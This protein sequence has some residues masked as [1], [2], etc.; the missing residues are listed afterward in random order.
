MLSKYI[1]NWFIL[2]FIL[3]IIMEKFKIYGHQF[4]NVYYTS[5]LTAIGFFVLYGYYLYQGVVFESSFL[6]FQLFTHISPIVILVRYYN[7][8][9]KN[10]LKTLLIVI[11]L[12]ILY[13]KYTNKNIDDIYF[14]KEKIIKTWN[15]LENSCIKNDNS[16]LCGIYKYLNVMISIKIIY[17]MLMINL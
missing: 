5:L 12:Y 11:I 17:L 15:N 16:L 7:T 10:A 9:F 1:S 2:L 8:K 4:L 14:H 13:L 3:W 6:L